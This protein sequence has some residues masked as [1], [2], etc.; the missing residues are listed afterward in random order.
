MQWFSYLAGTLLYETELALAGGTVLNWGRLGQALTDVY[1]KHFL[2]FTP[3][4]MGITGVSVALG[5][6]FDKQV[7]YRRAA[8]RVAATNGLP[9]LATRRFFLQGVSREV[10]RAVRFATNCFSRPFSSCNCL[11]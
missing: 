7:Q 1:R 6:L 9:L 11:S 8:E 10:A 5:Y 4:V 2:T 3:W